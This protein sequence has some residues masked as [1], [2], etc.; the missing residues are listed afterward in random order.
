[1]GRQNGKKSWSIVALCAMIGFLL[2]PVAISLNALA[3]GGGEA[4]P[5]PAV[6]AEGEKKDEAKVEK[7][8]DVYYKTEGIVSGAPAP[9]TVDGPSRKDWKGGR[10]AAINIIPSTTGAASARPRTCKPPWRACCGSTA[11]PRIWRA[12]RASPAAPT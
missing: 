10:T 12:R 11:T 4:P 1:M 9:K 5:A 6:K 7:G 2:L 8:R 3:S